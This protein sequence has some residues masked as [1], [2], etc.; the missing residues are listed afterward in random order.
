MNNKIFLKSK[1][2]K[3]REGGKGER[4]RRG[5]QVWGEQPLEQDVV[6]PGQLQSPHTRLDPQDTTQRADGTGYEPMLDVGDGNRGAVVS[7]PMTGTD[8]QAKRADDKQGQRARL[9]NAAV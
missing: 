1:H 5:R 9:V 3:Q 7:E 2:E 6:R 4:K 8:W